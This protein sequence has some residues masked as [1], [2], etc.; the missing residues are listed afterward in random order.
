MS[1]IFEGLGGIAGVSLFCL[2]L[3]FNRVTFGMVS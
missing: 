3:S 1:Q 2:P